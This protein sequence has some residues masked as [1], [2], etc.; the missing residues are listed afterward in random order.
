MWLQLQPLDDFEDW[1]VGGWVGGGLVL[2]YLSLDD[3]VWPLKDS[4][5]LSQ[6]LKTAMAICAIISRL[7]SN[8]AGGRGGEGG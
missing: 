8:L 1:W 5:Y 7:K 3:N 4:S 6:S 2:H